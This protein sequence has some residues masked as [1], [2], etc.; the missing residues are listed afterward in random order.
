MNFEESNKR[1]QEI[2][3][4]LEKNDISIEEGTALYEEGVKLSKNCYEILEKSKGKVNILKNELSS[5]TNG[6][7]EDF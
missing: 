6:E 7:D 3:Q 5:L 4:K 2:I 1:L